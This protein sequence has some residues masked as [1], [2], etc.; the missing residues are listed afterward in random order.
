MKNIAQYIIENTHN[1]DIDKLKELCKEF[2][3]KYYVNEGGCIYLAYLIAKKLELLNIK[4]KVNEYFDD[5][6]DPFHVS[7]VI[8]DIDINEPDNKYDGY[9][10]KR[11]W[12]SYQLMKHNKEF[13]DDMSFFWKQ[14]YKKEIRKEINIFFNI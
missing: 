7:L 13:E 11:D 12:N 2:N 14:K 1:I 8:N 4:F 6:D 3:K 10:K 9:V 5:R